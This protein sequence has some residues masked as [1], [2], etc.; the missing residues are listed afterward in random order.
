M[1]IGREKEKSVTESQHTTCGPE[2]ERKKVQQMMEEIE[3]MKEEVKRMKEVVRV[4]NREKEIAQRD[5]E[6]A[7]RKE[8]EA[9]EAAEKERKE[10]QQLIETKR[11][12]VETVKSME[13]TVQMAKKEK[14][15]A[16]REKEFAQKREREASEVAEKERELIRRRVEEAEAEARELK[17]HWV[18]RRN[19]IQPTDVE[20]GRGGWG[21]VMIANFRGIQV[22][23]KYL[24]KDLAS[25]Y[26]QDMFSREMNMAARLRHPNLVQF[27]GASID[28]GQPIILTELMKTSLRAEL[29]NENIKQHQVKLISLDV[30]R[31]LN[32]LHLM[33][34][35]P[36]IHRDI[37]S[38]NVLLDPLLDNQW[39]AKVT[40]YGSVNIQ[41][42]LHTV[43]PGSPVYSAP[44]AHTPA[45]QSP[46]MDIF[47]FGILLV[48]MLT[49]RFPEASSR[50]RLIASIDHAGYLAL[51]QQCLSE[52]RD[53]RP[54]AQHLIVILNDI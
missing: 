53:K 41:Q 34:P 44:E 12:R 35:H 4:A 9:R 27:I 1:Q 28:S 32:Y 3:R 39:R 7:Q 2:W 45:L 33:Q 42:K 30:V 26:Y 15:Q 31:A 37:S 18:V 51:I 36:I 40:D 29:E 25:S 46:K 8:R 20:L 47:S 43:G 14:E 48:E 17:T 24:Y 54:S 49:S 11:I 38:A 10:I 13:E 50:Q 5:R 23:A 19:E 16:L 6:V 22:A 21:A 52:D